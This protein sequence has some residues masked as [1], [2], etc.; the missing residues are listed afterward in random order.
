[1]SWQFFD[2]LE[3]GGAVTCLLD[4][5]TWSN[6]VIPLVVERA[7]VSAGAARWRVDQTFSP[8]SENKP[9]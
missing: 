7:A 9:K 5:A 1:M 3:S 8:H 4:N 6:P 2:R